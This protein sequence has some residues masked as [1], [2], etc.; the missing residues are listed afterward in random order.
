MPTGSP[1]GPWE[2]W[3]SLLCLWPPR[4]PIANYPKAVEQKSC[5]STCSFEVVQ[6][7]HGYPAIFD[8]CRLLAVPATLEYCFKWLSSQLGIGI[9][10]SWLQKCATFCNTYIYIYFSHIRQVMLFGYPATCNMK[11]KQGDISFPR[12]AIQPLL[13]LQGFE[14][15]CFH[16]FQN[17]QG[18]ESIF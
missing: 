6:A 18:F 13:I 8:I 11:T 3:P 12:C 2:V 7:V 10:T 4:I 16:S 1:H 5:K 17:A 9:A 15:L 14:D